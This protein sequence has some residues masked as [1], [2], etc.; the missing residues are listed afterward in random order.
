M[1]SQAGLYSITQAQAILGQIRNIQKSLSSGHKERHDL[2]QV[3][4]VMSCDEQGEA[5]LITGE[6]S[7][8][9]WWTR[10]G[11]TYYRWDKSC[12]VMN[13][14]KHDLLQVRQ[15]MSCDEQGEAWL[16]TGETSHIMWWTR[17]GTTYYR[18]DKSCHVMNKERHDL[19]QVRQVISC[20]EQ[21]EAWLI[22]GETSHVV[23]W[24]RRGTTYYRWDKSCHVMNKERHDLLQVRQVMSCDEQGEARLITDETSHIVWWTRRGTTYYRWDKS[25]HVMNKERHDL[26]QVRQ[27]ISCDEQ[28]E[29][30]LI[31]GETS[32][33]MWWTR[34][35]TTYYRWDKSC[36]VM[37][38]E[39]HDLLQVRQVMSCDEQGE[40]RLIT[41]ETSHVMWWTRRGTTYYRW[42]KSCHV[43]NKERHDLLQVRQVMS[44]D[45][46]GE[47]RLN[48][49]DTSHDVWWTRRRTTYYRWDKSC[50]VMNK[51]RH[52]LLQVRQVMSCDEQGEARL[53]TGDTSHVMWW[54]RRGTTSY[55]WDK[56]CHVM[57]KERH[58]LLQV[59]QVMSCDEQG[60]ARL[61]TGETS[62]V[63][64]TRRG[65]T[66]YRWDKSCHVM[67]K[68]RHD[69]L[70]V[71][72]VMS[73]DEQGEARLITGET[74]HVV[75]WTRRGTTYYR[76]DKSCRV[77]N[78]ERHDL[79]Q[80]RQVISC[81][82]QG[83]ARLI[84]GETSHVMWWTRS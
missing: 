21:G 35:G 40:A 26:L 71:R 66:S 82:E 6:T 83:E 68:E 72:Q 75:W 44:C 4:Q 41:G 14:E 23:W 18:W 62:H 10:R 55:R 80:V 37:N 59:R 56:S 69:F 5:R 1:A 61:I 13:K 67:N 78:K 70:Q 3:R 52:D 7:H 54:T 65:T 33:V 49:G 43:M 12:H 74:S 58:D 38:K 25:C 73:C 17:R 29:A 53:I 45:E 76:W 16:I 77:M 32:H 15:V 31:T 2:L 79:L 42:D 22:T 50:H 11:T 46:Q 19:L 51:E 24:T 84:T 64:W 9:M 28:G 30:R 27:V 34:R 57:N 39:R 63:W 48:T 81:D 20:D 36:H 60:E 8:V 47:A